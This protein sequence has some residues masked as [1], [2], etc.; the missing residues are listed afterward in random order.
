[1]P[2][3]EKV[4]WQWFR[5][6]AVSKYAETHGLAGYALSEKPEGEKADF[7]E[8]GPG[9]FAAARNKFKNYKLRKESWK[10][11]WNSVKHPCLSYCDLSICRCIKWNVFCDFETN[12]DLHKITN[13]EFIWT[14]LMDVYIKKPV[15]WPSDLFLFYQLRI[16]QNPL[17]SLKKMILF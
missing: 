4:K 2:N 6:D 10:W 13:N 1:M 17:M 7:Y 3:I 5:I 12:N 9:R 11:V 15:L 8:V 14:H 16:N